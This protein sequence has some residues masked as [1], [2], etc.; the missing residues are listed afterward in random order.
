AAD[1]ATGYRAVAAFADRGPKAAAFLTAHIR[2]AAAPTAD[3]LRRWG[4]ELGAPS[5]AVREAAARNLREH[6]A[7]AQPGLEAL[8]KDSK[9]AE[10]RKR[11]AELM[12]LPDAVA[13]PEEVRQLRAAAAL[14]RLRS[15]DGDK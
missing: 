2:P 7:A 14:D 4:D 5:F 15:I 1:A 9:S 12:A 3:Q 8:Q 6:R 10:V 13:S 11:A